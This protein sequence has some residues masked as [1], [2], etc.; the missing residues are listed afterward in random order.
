MQQAKLTTPGCPR[1]FSIL[2]LLVAMTV[3]LAVMSAAG[4]LLASS[5]R[6]RNRENNRSSALAAAQRA[7][8]IM[9]REIGNSGYGLVDNGL[10]VGD[11]TSNSVRIRGNLDNDL[12]L[13]DTDED[14]R[15]VYQAENKAIVRFDSFPAPNGTTTVLADGIDS[16]TLRYWNVG[17]VE[18]TDPANYFQAE[19]IT[20][21]VQVILPAGLEQPASLV[22]LVSDVALRNGPNTI[23]KF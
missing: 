9:S 5:F 8:N 22:R 6:I 23:Q 20:I 17:G 18:I 4:S 15:Y 16:L 3:T 7:L 13:T 2:E 12:T 21:N 1:G 11:C 19:R 10:V 14:I